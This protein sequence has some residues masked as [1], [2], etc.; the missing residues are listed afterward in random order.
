MFNFTMTLNDDQKAFALSL[1]QFISCV[2]YKDKE[3]Y[4]AHI[5]SNPELADAGRLFI[6][7]F[8]SYIE[9]QDKIEF[10]C[11]DHEDGIE[12]SDP[13]DEWANADD[14]SNFVKAILIR[15]DMHDVISFD[16]KI[17]L[18]NGV[19]TVTQSS[20]SCETEG[21]NILP[22]GSKYQINFS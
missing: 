10:V 18:R 17:E 3:A 11:E 20:I 19:F 2:D 12:L 16:D 14:V 22:S 4:Q 9:E 6:F 8:D 21:D 1:Y 13:D 15:F 7:D 5:E